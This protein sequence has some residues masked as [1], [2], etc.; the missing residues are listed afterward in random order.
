[1]LNEVNYKSEF[2]LSKVDQSSENVAATCSDGITCLGCP[3]RLHKCQLT[4][5]LVLQVH[6]SLVSLVHKFHIFDY[7]ISLVS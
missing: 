5:H 1:M 3:S 7:S 4:N 6:R 2:D